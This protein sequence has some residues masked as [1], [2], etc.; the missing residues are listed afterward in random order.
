MKPMMKQDSKAHEKAESKKKERTEKE[1]YE[2]KG[3]MMK[4][5][6]QKCAMDK[7]K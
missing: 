3:D 6:C 4:D 2:M 5:G 7:V 1:P